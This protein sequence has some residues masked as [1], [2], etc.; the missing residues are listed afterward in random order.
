MVTGLAHAQAAP[1]LLVWPGPKNHNLVSIVGW[2]SIISSHQILV[3]TGQH[4]K[5]AKPWTLAQAGCLL[6]SGIH[7]SSQQVLRPS[8]TVSVA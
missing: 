6:M 3:Q 1:L 5:P 8:H 4:V 7:I 2:L